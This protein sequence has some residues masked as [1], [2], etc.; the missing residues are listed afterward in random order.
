MD[1]QKR[2]MQPENT[3]NDKTYFYGKQ[4]KFLEIKK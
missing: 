4:L 3:T 1:L 2:S